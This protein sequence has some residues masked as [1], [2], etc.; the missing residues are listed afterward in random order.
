MHIQNQI[1]IKIKS[2]FRLPL[3]YQTVNKILNKEIQLKQYCQ[4]ILN[5]Y[6]QYQTIHK[7][8]ICTL[9]NQ[10]DLP[11]CKTC[12]KQLSYSE[13]TKKYCSKQCTPNPYTLPE[14]K[15]KIKQTHIKNL[16]VPYPAQSKQVNEKCAK[17]NLER[18]GCKAPMQNKQI[19][20]KVKITCL[21]KYGAD[22][23]MRVEQ[24]KN[25]LKQTNLQKYGTEIYTDSQDFKQKKKKTCR[26]K[27]NKD[28]PVPNIKKRVQTQLKK[29][30]V[31]HFTQ[32][33]QF[34]EKSKQTCLQKYGTEYYSQ[35][36]TALEKSYANMFRWNDQV[37]PNFTLNEFTGYHNNEMYEWK[38]LKC[39][40]I[41]KSTY[42]GHTKP[43]CLNC[44]PLDSGFSNA[45]KQITNFCK[46]F[47]PKLLQNNRVLIKPY[48]L[49]IVIPQIKLAIEFN[50]LYWHSIEN[51]Y[52]L[53]YHLMKTEMCEKLGYRLIHI[54]ENETDQAIQLL[55]NIF[56]KSEQINMQN[57]LDRCI[58][59]AKQI[60]GYTMEILP[61]EILIKNN[62]QIE[63]CG[64]LKYIKNE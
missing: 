15:Q 34:K 29:Y 54:W 33:E 26:E 9:K 58:Y 11:K 6:P 12:G 13:R 60:K 2:L 57:I 24:I 5:Q 17:T 56:N 31:Q 10:L 52:Q 41:F 21:Q 47:F 53:G 42:N 3:N 32:S 18:Y 22:H 23:P 14:V 20:N 39:N 61:P 43:R 50:G 27:Y 63:N 25:K 16:G 48:Q 35:S 37:V 49:D 30:G 8:I 64:Y 36:K 19:Q 38:C 55:T 1:I 51:G 44:Y 40:S 28:N 62:Y 4:T 46:Q 45:E 59:P 7:L